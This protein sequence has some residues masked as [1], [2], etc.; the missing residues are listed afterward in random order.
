MNKTK[1]GFTLLEILTVVAIIGLLAAMIFPNL[2][3][4]RI[5]ARK[6][7]VISELKTI[8]L[9]LM[10][11][12]TEHSGFP[13]TDILPPP[14]SGLYKLFEEDYLDTALADA[15]NSPQPYEYYSSKDGG[16]TADSCLVFSVGPDSKNNGAI[17]WLTAH[18]DV[19]LGGAEP[20]SD[21]IY[22]VIDPSGREGDIRYKQ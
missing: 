11:Y 10:D 9:A 18:A 19:N 14:K 7:K 21:N 17:D 1:A 13:T 12:Y 8:E 5:R 2:G 15:F 6:A 20:I 22:L 16:D 4:V 3:K